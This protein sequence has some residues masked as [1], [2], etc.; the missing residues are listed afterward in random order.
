MNFSHHHRHEYPWPAP[1]ALL[2]SVHAALAATALEPDE[3]DKIAAKSTVRIATLNVLNCHLVNLVARPAEVLDAAARL[4]LLLDTFGTLAA[5]DT[6]VALQE[7]PLGWLSA[8]RRHA[9]KLGY[10]LVATFSKLARGVP[11]FMGVALAW[12]ARAYDATAVDARQLHEAVG[13]PRQ[14]SPPR[15][16]AWTNVRG[17]VSA[18]VA[19]RLR[20]RGGAGAAFVAASVHLPYDGRLG[21][22]LRPTQGVA[23]AIAA[24]HVAALANRSS[25]TLPHALAGDFNAPPGTTAHSVMLGQESPP[26]PAR[27]VA[28]WPPA[29]PRRYRSAYAAAAGAEPPFTNVVASRGGGAPATLTLDYVWVSDEWRVAAADP[30]PPAAA[31]EALPN[32]TW[33]SDHLLLAV[34]LALPPTSAPPPPTTHRTAHRL[35]ERPLEPGRWAFEGAAGGAAAA[36]AALEASLAELQR[37]C[38]AL[39]F[40]QTRGCRCPS[41]SRAQTC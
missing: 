33:P 4:R 16:A 25:A 10:R 32:R 6:V 8:L 31:A 29:A 5:S 37:L 39:A 3:S 14:P 13:W 38:A 35:R 2:H 1:S 9:R 15:D 23:A 7:V 27:S 11:G 28:W 19:A 24:R 41:L 18:I 40:D 20:Q 22:L 36:E 30:L 26:Q 34:E 21:A 17:A 12:P